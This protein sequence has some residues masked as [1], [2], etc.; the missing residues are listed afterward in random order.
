[1]E[2]TS[3]G[4]KPKGAPRG[5]QNA[6]RHGLRGRQLSRE[7]RYIANST[8][9]F[10]RECEAAVIASHGE[11]NIYHAALVQSAVRHETR[12]QLIGRWL[13]IA[14]EKGETL[15]LL[16]RANLLKQLSDAS[17]ARDRCLEKMDISKPS[18]RPPWEANSGPQAVLVLPSNGRVAHS[19]QSLT[20]DHP[21]AGAVADAGEPITEGSNE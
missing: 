16:D 3:E 6:R 8:T 17:D 11:V 2:T 1:M 4:T 12:A 10:Q 13:R 7:E 20:S 14:E 15:T 19:P 18:P 5:N 9:T 21:A